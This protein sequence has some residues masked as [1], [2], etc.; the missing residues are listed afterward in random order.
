VNAS[1]VTAKY[2]HK[3]LSNPSDPDFCFTRYEFFLKHFTCLS[4]WDVNTSKYII[5]MMCTDTYAKGSQKQMTFRS[6]NC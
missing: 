3:A 5:L 2:A 6:T 4:V 1:S